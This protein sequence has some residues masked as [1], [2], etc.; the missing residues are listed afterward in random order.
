MERILQKL[1][2]MIL[3]DLIKGTLDQGRNCLI[4]F[5]EQESTELFE[6]A[7]ETFRN[8]DAAVDS[9]YDKT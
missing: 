3:D 4:L 6:N 1:S 2:E 9:L 5:E 7:L 8:L